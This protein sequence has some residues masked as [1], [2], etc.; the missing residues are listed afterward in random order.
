MK[1][2][3]CIIHVKV[4]NLD[5]MDTVNERLCI[6][7]SLNLM[8]CIY[9]KVVFCV[10]TMDGLYLIFFCHQ[11]SNDIIEKLLMLG[12]E[13]VTCGLLFFHKCDSNGACKTELFM[14]ET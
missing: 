8:I 4:L 13:V 9:A 2:L 11:K 6:Q 12:R 7:E 5:A 3:K 10:G 1:N 14:A